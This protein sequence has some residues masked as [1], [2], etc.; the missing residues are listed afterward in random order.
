MQKTSTT[1]ARVATKT[2]QTLSGARPPADNALKGITTLFDT[3]AMSERFSNWLSPALGALASCEIEYVR[4]K[5]QTNCLIC[6]ILTFTT[7]SNDT[8]EERSYAKLFTHSDY[9]D[10]CHKLS[11]KRWESH[12]SA[13]PTYLL[14]QEKAILYRFPNDTAL[15]GLRTLTTPKRLQRILY[16]NLADYPKVTWRISDSKLNLTVASYKPE[17]RAVLHIATKATNRS[18]AEKRPLSIYIRFYSDERGQTQIDCLKTLQT[19]HNSSDSLLT[20]QPICYLPEDRALLA[21]SI[22]GISLEELSTHND[23]IHYTELTAKALATLHNT[24]ANIFPSISHNQLVDQLRQELTTTTEYIC[25]LVPE[26]QETASTIYSNL[27]QY[28]DKLTIDIGLT[29]G[30]FHPGQ[31]IYQDEHIGII[32]FDRA[33]NGP[34]LADLANYIANI[35]QLPED[36]ATSSISEIEDAL[37]TFYES[38]TTTNIDKQ[39]LSFWIAYKLFNMAVTPFRK[40]TPN[41]RASVSNILEQAN[42][43]LQHTSLPSPSQKSTIFNKATNI[44][45]VTP[46]LQSHLSKAVGFDIQIAELE[47]PRAFV[48][49]IDTTLIQYVISLKH[50]TTQ[51]LNNVIIYGELDPT[52]Q[53]NNT[54]YINELKMTLRIFPHDTHLRELTNCFKSHSGPLWFKSTDFILNDSQMAFTAQEVH[55]YRQGKRCVMRGLIKGHLNKQLS[56]NS[57]YLKLSRP[58]YT[59]RALAAQDVINMT[60]HGNN[61]EHFTL[62]NI[63]FTNIARGLII[64]EAVN[65]PTLYTMLKTHSKAPSASESFKHIESACHKIGV[66]LR[67]FQSGAVPIDIP[68]KTYTAEQEIDMLKQK[69]A[70]T[71]LLTPKYAQQLKQAFVSLENYQPKTNTDSAALSHRDFY[72]KQLFIESNKITLID[73]DTLSLADPFLDTANFLAHLTLRGNQEL[74]SKLQHSKAQEHFINGYYQ[75]SKNSNTTNQ[76]DS[77]IQLNWWYKATMLRLATL[78]ALRPKWRHLTQQLIDDSHAGLPC[79]LLALQTCN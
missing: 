6:Y 13:A 53:G 79:Q 63:L 19:E 50:A 60:I 14:E 51:Q 67:N 65:A 26:A 2:V 38:A 5:P 27:I 33:K 78:Y 73:L 56:S 45:Y 3:R 64:T 77:M 66:L 43:E 72:D 76:S 52:Q 49:S 39:E 8:I 61:K 70:Q 75:Q 23:I 25:S 62:A 12:D 31:V 29:H 59:A 35:R 48:K 9:A 40:C 17:R 71:S 20:P 47:I 28:L 58:R 41:W 18:T 46:I 36:N 10:A 7:A 22:P 68:L 69:V 1:T 30:D 42:N 24:T 74:L 11:A 37:T 55:S 44:D 34:Q 32:D 57:V 54:D 15:K 21:Y 4:Y 16:Q